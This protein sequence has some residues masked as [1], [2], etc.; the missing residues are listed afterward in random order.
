MNRE[1]TTSITRIAS[2]ETHALTVPS[3]GAQM[4]LYR[5]ASSSDHHAHADG[6]IDVVSSSRHDVSAES[7]SHDSLFALPVDSTYPL[8]GASPQRFV[9]YAYDPRSDLALAPGSE[10]A[11]D[12]D[13]WLFSSDLGGRGR[14]CALSWRGIVNI[15]TVAFIFGTI[16]AFFICYPVISF[17]LDES[18]VR[19]VSQV[20]YIPPAN[21]STS[22]VA[23]TAATAAAMAL[24][25]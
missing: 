4:I 15:G 1:N 14:S 23:A 13:D 10:K 21:T 17:Y 6:D 18:R 11:E 9:P 24:E 20:G 8:T 3:S 16:F 7:A 22:A 2:E 5:L 12:E 19:D 25:A